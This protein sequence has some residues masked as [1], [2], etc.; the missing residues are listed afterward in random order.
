MA[1]K[2]FMAMGCNR[3]WNY[4]GDVWRFLP[5]ILPTSRLL[6]E[7]CLKNVQGNGYAM[8]IK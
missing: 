2:F 3:L 5:N 8:K 4:Y 7:T 1:N 6:S